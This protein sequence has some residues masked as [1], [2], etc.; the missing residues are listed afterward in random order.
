[1]G[2]AEFRLGSMHVPFKAET[3]EK[4]SC[5]ITVGNTDP[6]P[7]TYVHCKCVWIISKDEEGQE[8]I[9]SAE[10]E[11]DVWTYSDVVVTF[12]FRMPAIDVYVGAVLYQLINDNWQIVDSTAMIKVD[13]PA[14]PP[15]WLQKFL[16]LEIYKWLLIASIIGGLVI[17]YS[18]TRS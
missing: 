1:M 13:N 3:G 8:I 14:Y 15:W 7:L 2:R 10:I 17:G 18:A 4:V 6:E 11:F 16:G 9:D 12:T 5:D